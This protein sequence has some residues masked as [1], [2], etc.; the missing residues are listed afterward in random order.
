MSK[1]LFDID[2][3]RA[4]PLPT[5]GEI[6]ANW[7]GDIDKPVVSILCNTFNHK[8]YIED[9]FRGFLIQKTD[10]VFEVI[11]HDDA[12][13]DGTSDIVRQYAKCYPHIFKPLIQTENQYSKGQAP[14]IISFPYSKGKYIALC[15][16]DDFWIYEGKLQDYINILDSKV[17]ISIVASEGYIRK[18]K[19]GDSVKKISVMDELYNLPLYLKVEPFIMTC[20]IMARRNVFECF[21]FSNHDYF[22]GDTRLKLIA[23]TFGDMFVFSQA[24]SIYNKGSIGSWSNRKID[25]DLLLTELLDNISI[26][27][28]IN[29]LSG[30]R[31]SYE[32][33][34][35]V[36]ELS[37]KY[38]VL[39]Y[40]AKGR[41]SMVFYLL[42]NI[43]SIKVKNYKFL[44][45]CFFKPFS[46]N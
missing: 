38:E 26:L 28:E 23:L 8:N 29:R 40:A 7:Q 42:L 6:M 32:I 13:T 4:K 14:T 41:L 36:K 19:K 5:E 1:E 18:V 17:D 22:A 3:F 20:S 24:M 39:C 27:R 43:F 45:K 12:S 15:E 35:R 9:A 10:F 46:S 31:F 33:F 44:A 2:A 37:F 25:L 16:G 11:V 30:S 21:S 34:V